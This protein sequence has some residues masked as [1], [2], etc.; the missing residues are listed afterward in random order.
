[1]RPGVRYNINRDV[2][3]GYLI[4]FATR[5]KQLPA[6]RQQHLLVD[7]WGLADFADSTDQAVPEMRHVLLHLLRPD[8]FE[9]ISS[10]DHK[11]R[12]VEA[13]TDRLSDGEKS[14]P[15]DKQLCAI[16]EALGAEGVQ[17]D[18][19]VLDFYR[20]PFRDQWH[21]GSPRQPPL[22]VV[23]PPTQASQLFFFTAGT[24]AAA[25]HYHERHLNKG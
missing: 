2:Q 8:E 11:A 13:F 5:F 25:Q 19:P 7:P 15:V 21:P 12:I 24:G 20:P 22:A 23:E 3:I 9:R 18:E 17:P 16:R 4:D 14:Q 1:M 10:K 6:D